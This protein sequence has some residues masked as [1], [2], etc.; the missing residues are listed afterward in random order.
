MSRWGC[1][2]RLNPQ[3]IADVGYDLVLI[4][5]RYRHDGTGLINKTFAEA[6]QLR[7]F[8]STTAC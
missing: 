6:V 5:V 8:V 3:P 7:P 4:D 1:V 2:D